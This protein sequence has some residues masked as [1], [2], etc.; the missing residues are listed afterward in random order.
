VFDNHLIDT[1]E[2]DYR[3][4]PRTPEDCTIMKKRVP[5]TGNW[6]ALRKGGLP[7][8]SSNGDSI[9]NTRASNNCHDEEFDDPRHARVGETTVTDVSRSPNIAAATNAIKMALRKPAGE[10]GA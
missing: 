3:P 10:I 1:A 2:P 9:A 7:P 8:Q 6:A 5:L 4:N